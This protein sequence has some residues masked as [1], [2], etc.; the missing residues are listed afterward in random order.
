MLLSKIVENDES[1]RETEKMKKIFLEV[2][3]NSLHPF[4]S[5]QEIL[6]EDIDITEGFIYVFKS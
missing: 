4:L 2:L 3:C 1:E 5:L 6:L